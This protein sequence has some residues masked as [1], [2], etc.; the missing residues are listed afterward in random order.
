LFTQPDLVGRGQSARSRE[1]L[2]RMVGLQ[3]VAAPLGN[4]G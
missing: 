3:V 4:Q 2:H 1:G